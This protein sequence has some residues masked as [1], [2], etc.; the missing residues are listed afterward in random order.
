MLHVLSVVLENDG[1][2]IV[3]GYAKVVK[4]FQNLLSSLSD[5]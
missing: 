4:K 1:E 3:I 5:N 2:I